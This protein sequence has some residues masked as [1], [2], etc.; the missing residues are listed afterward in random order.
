MRIYDSVINSIN[1]LVNAAAI[2][3][4][5]GKDVP[6]WT[7]GDQNSLLFKDEIA[8]ELGR[9]S[10][11]GLAGIALT[12]NE[13][14]LKDDEIV[15]IGQ[16]I[17]EIKS[18]TPYARVVIALVDDEKMGE[19]NLLYQSIRKIDYTRYH[20]NPKGMMVRISSMNSKETLVVSKTA[21]KEHASFQSLGKLYI[22]AYKK[23]PAVKAVKVI[24]ITDS[25]FN[26]KDLDNV[27]GKS[28]AIAKSLDHLANKVKMDCHSCA[29][30]AVCNEVEALTKKDFKKE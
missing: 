5:K 27:L 6:S 7:E 18:E 28:E 10:L 17:D 29:I 9:G 3:S 25:K 11:P 20:I 19:G 8:Y 26:Y 21:L 4:F 1:E 22:N 14:V 2:K 30:Q 16:D 24:F 15:L 23:N 13:T 12:S